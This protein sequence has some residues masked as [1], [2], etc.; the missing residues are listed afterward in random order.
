[1]K[2]FVAKQGEIERKWYLVNAD[3]K[4]L[5]RI[6]T[7]IAQILRGKTKPTFTPHLDCGDYVVVINAEKVK[8]TGKKEAQKIYR[9]HSG[10][11]GN[12]RLTLAKDIKAKDPTRLIE[13]A[14]CGMI[15]D[16]KLREFVMRKL[17]VYAGATHA[18]TAQNPTEIT[19]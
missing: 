17:K 19:L 12:I 7:K 14:V 4:V 8:L 13:E 18:H 5:G 9:S 2:T 6:A 10:Y 16:N 1:M 3:G 11:L 15:P